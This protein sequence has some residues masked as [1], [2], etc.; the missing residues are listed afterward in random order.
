MK[1]KISKKHILVFLTIFLILFLIS[2]LSACALFDV[3]KSD[4]HYT[5]SI[6]SNSILVQ[7]NRS[8]INYDSVFIL[9]PGS[10]S[11]SPL[12]G[13][14]NVKWE[15]DDY[16]SIAQ[17]VHH[18]E[19]GDNLSDWD[20]VDEVV[21]YDCTGIE[22]G[23]VGIFYRYSKVMGNSY[24]L[25]SMT[26]NPNSNILRTRHTEYSLRISEWDIID[27]ERTLTADEALKIAEESGGKDECINENNL[28]SI[29]V[30]YDWSPSH[31]LMWAIRYDSNDSGYFAKYYID[32]YTGETE[33]IR[34]EK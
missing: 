8:E 18:F 15:L 17:A 21:Y 25:S 5:Y 31:N 6:D 29:E 26:I 7:L 33:S 28:C 1:Q 14:T 11:N 30:F 22:D 20:L 12:F 2:P 10:V 3:E 24:Y 32:A 4:T 16:Y 27:V 34:V 19:W 13:R 23:A 9:E